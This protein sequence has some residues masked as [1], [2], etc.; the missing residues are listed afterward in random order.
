MINFLIIKQAHPQ[1]LIKRSR[2]TM[3]DKAIWAY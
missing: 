3:F 1:G 2:D